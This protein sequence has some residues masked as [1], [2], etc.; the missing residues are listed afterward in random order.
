M[1]PW[2]LRGAAPHFAASSKA[3]VPR[4][5][6]FV[7]LGARQALEFGLHWPLGVWTYSRL[8]DATYG[9]QRANAILGSFRKKSFL[10]TSPYRARGV[11]EANSEASEACAS[12]ARTHHIALIF[13]VT[14]FRGVRNANSEV[15]APQARTHDV[16]SVS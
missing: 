8:S 10:Q 5:R 9:C 1:L 6:H 11:R 16:A 4:S 7:A 15:S 12:Q 3:F 13:Y 14:S 2:C